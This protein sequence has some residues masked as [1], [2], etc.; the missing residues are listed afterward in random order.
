[1]GQIMSLSSALRL[2]ARGEMSSAAERYWYRENNQLYSNRSN[3]MRECTDELR[4]LY[5]TQSDV[6]EKQVCH[7]GREV[8]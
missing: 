3:C 6:Q 7:A 1:M 5:E 8:W 2:S 4:T